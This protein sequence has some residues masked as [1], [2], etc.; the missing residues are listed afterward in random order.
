MGA[1]PP[2]I[3]EVPGPADSCSLQ[4]AMSHAASL[5]VLFKIQDSEAWKE[6][7]GQCEKAKNLPYVPFLELITL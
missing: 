1:P 5:A 4:K 6:G 2:C 7:A 3:P